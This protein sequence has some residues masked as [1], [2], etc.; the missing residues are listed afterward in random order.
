MFTVDPELLEHPSIYVTRS[1]YDSYA[2]DSRQ[3]L[4]RT[5]ETRKKENL[6]ID[7]F[8]NTNEMARTMQWLADHGF[9]D[10][11]DFERKDVIRRIWFTIFSGSTCGF[12]RVFGSENY[13]VAI[14]GVQD[15]I[16]F[17][18]QESL[19]R[20]DYMGYVDKLNLGSV[21]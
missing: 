17:Q 13:G 18:N 4:N 7:T 5:L 12:E 11:D 16:Y 14:V 20:I 1:L 8:L 3:K 9:I 10:P 21:S 6:L 15:W 19:G 2:H